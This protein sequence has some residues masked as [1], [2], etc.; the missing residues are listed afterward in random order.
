[1]SIALHSGVDFCL[2]IGANAFLCALLGGLIVALHRTRDT[3]RAGHP[4]AQAIDGPWAE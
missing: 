4:S 1:L 3:G 2:Q